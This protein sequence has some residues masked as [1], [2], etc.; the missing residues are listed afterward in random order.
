[1]TVIDSLVHTRDNVN[2][3]RDVHAIIIIR[4]LRRGIKLFRE[5]DTLHEDRSFDSDCFDIRGRKR[6]ERG[7][8]GK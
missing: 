6:L 5:R 2:A 3:V 7:N 8:E 1:M 4:R